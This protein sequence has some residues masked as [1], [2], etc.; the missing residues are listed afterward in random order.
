MPRLGFRNPALVPT[1][2]KEHEVLIILGRRLDAGNFKA[3]RGFPALQRRLGL[4]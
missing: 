3:S 1:L 4:F 2:D